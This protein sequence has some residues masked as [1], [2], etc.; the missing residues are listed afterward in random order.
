MPD[1]DPI[2]GLREAWGD[3]EAPP[4]DR[5]LEAPDAETRAALEWMREAWR[6]LEPPA[7]RIPWRVRLA[8]RAGGL[9]PI[10]AAAAVLV[11][12]V[13][14]GRGFFDAPSRPHEA[15][16]P[17]AALP[18]VRIASLDPDRMELRSGPVRLILLTPE[19]R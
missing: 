10:A 4:P 1:R 19:V 8:R 9:R 15:V 13:V 7:A 11:A 18:E 3:L 5:V 14:F 17:L 6:A 12:A 2:E 16:Q